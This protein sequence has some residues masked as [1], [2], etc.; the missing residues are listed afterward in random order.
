MR[1]YLF[2][3]FYFSLFGN[4]SFVIF[5]IICS[6]YYYAFVS[7]GVVVKSFEITAY[8]FEGAGFI[9]NL[10]S[11]IFLFRTV[12]ART[13]MKIGYC[14]YIVVELVLM[15]FELN[16]YQI[17]FYKPYSLT[18]AIIHS[19]FSAGICFL[20]LFLEPKNKYLEIM[21]VVAVG[22]MFFGMMG[23]IFGIRIY[24]SI[25]VNSVAYIVLFSSI[26]FMLKQEK[27]EIDCYGDKARFKQYKSSFFEE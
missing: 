11:S 26:I 21:T 25:L 2:K 14:V 5:A 3:C 7:I 24:F 13:P 6:V 8:I 16:S 1:K 10:I 22:I 15:I 4:I 18:L 9:L 19:M 27:I 17:S 12:R 23:N 20:F